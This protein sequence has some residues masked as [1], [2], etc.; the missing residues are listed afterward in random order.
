MHYESLKQNKDRT[1]KVPLNII[2]VN[3]ERVQFFAIVCSPIVVCSIFLSWKT[4]IWYFDYHVVAYQ[5]VSA[6]Q[7]PATGNISWGTWTLTTVRDTRHSHQLGAQEIWDY[8]IV[9]HR[10]VS[11]RQVP[12]TGNISWGRWTLTTVRDTRTAHQ[13]GTQEICIL[14]IM[15]LPT[16]QFQET[17]VGAHELAQQLGTQDILI[18]WE[19]K[20]LII[21]LSSC[22]PPGSFK[23]H[24]L[25]N[26]HNS[27]GNPT[28]SSVG[29][30]RNLIICL[31]FCCPPAGFKKHQLGHMKSHNS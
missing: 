17:S 13:L 12:A 11:A 14:T 4:E 9:A 6:C 18:S 2:N 3:D 29:N 31:S 21:W 10:A 15:L 5:A 22:C 20:N 8:D 1:N 7:V 23:K 16:R 30:T 24:Q 25:G 27:Q 26:M 28:F 19:H